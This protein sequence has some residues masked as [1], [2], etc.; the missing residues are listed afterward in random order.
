MEDELFTLVNQVCTK[1]Y[2]DYSLPVSEILAAFIL[3]TVIQTNPDRYPVTGSPDSTALNDLINA[4]IDR[5]TTQNDPAL[6]TIKMQVEYDSSYLEEEETLDNAAVQRERKCKESTKTVVT[7][8]PKTATDFETINT[9]YTFIFKH[10]LIDHHPDGV[11]Q[12]LISM[13]LIDTKQKDPKVVKSLILEV[14]KEI[15]AALESVFPR[16]GVKSFALLATSKK[17]DQLVEL[18]NIILGIRLLNKSTNKGGV[19][20]RDIDVEVNDLISSLR[21][22]IAKEV[23]YLQELVTQYQQ[24][25]VYGHLVLLR[26]E[27]SPDLI[28]VV[29]R[30]KDELS[31]RRQYLAYLQGLQEDILLSGRTVDDLL[32]KFVQQIKELIHL[33]NGRQSVPKEQVYPKFDILAQ[34]WRQLSKERETLLSRKKIY[35]RLKQ[36]RLSYK[37]LLSSHL[38]LF[39][40][41]MKHQANGGMEPMQQE[42]E[43]ARA[44]IQANKHIQNQTVE[45][46]MTQKPSTDDQIT[47]KE[48]KNEIYQNNNNNDSVDASIINNNNDTM[49]TK[50]S[51]ANK[52]INMNV[53][54]VSGAGSIPRTANTASTISGGS[55]LEKPVKLDIESTPEF[56]QLPLEYQGFCAWTALNRRGLLLPG[57]PALGVVRYRNNFYVFAHE[58]ALQAFMENPEQLIEGL[59]HRAIHQSPELIH[60]L[61]LQNYFPS[62]SIRSLLKSASDGRQ[63]T[64]ESGVPGLK[65]KDTK[66]FGT[67]TPTHFVTC[68]KDNKYLWNVWDQRRRALAQCHLTHCVTVGSQTDS[69]HYKRENFTQAY[70]QKESTTQTRKESGTNPPVVLTYMAGLRDSD[71]TNEKIKAQIDKVSIVYEHKFATK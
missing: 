20:I 68:K 64:E 9:I 33:V 22:G 4:A 18:S 27:P 17:I 47:N 25:L 32:L 62:T 24:T 34:I 6:E 19:G 3:R 65:V 46:A 35:T 55:R 49:K 15:A 45:D 67:Q 21:D 41:A 66:E 29:D 14:E 60:L 56:L 16:I 57:R 23:E 26:N 58:V 40:A 61:R 1:C 63:S 54:I 50:S 59:N 11:E 37:P 44:T 69:S 10:L 7:T 8:K 70:L 36:F 42:E 38:P 31:N 71:L 28:T 48:E 13:G 53:S 52:S 30:L 12:E 5:L 43:I 39:K 2:R 51:D